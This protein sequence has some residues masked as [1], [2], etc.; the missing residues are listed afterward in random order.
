[1]KLIR[2]IHNI[3]P[4]HRGT[5]ATIGN[6]DGIHRGHQ[7]IVRQLHELARRL[8]T[9]TTVMTFD[10]LPREYFMGDKAPARLS[11]LREKFIQFDRLGVDQLLTTPFNAKLAD[12]PAQ[13]F[14]DDILVRGLAIEALVVGD[15]FRFGKGREGDFDMLRHAGEH[16]G[17]EVIDTETVVDDGERISS[18]RIRNA[19]AAGDL[20][21]AARLLG[22]PY[23]M[24]GTVVHGEKLGRT[25]GF[26]TANIRVHRTV[27]PLHGVFAVEVECIGYGVTNVG[28]R[29]TVDGK[30]FLIET[31][32]LDFDGDLYGQHINIRWLKKLRGE[33]KFDSLD[34]LKAQIHKDIDAAR[35]YFAQ[36][37]SRTT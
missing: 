29:P 9:K 22:R 1:M 8:D 14:I 18:T 24:S 34:A 25:I 33:Q 35:A 5:V 19:L 6:F 16:Y 23:S 13:Q 26:P 36:L 21:L 15:D 28:T 27:S 3:R 7:A 2:G 4:E 37:E 30:G 10:P 32:L 11:T 17:F 12:M 20:T 31:H